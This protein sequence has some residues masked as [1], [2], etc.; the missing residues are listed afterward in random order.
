MR[1]SLE[2]ALQ[3]LRRN[4][5][6]Y[7]NDPRDPGGCTNHGITLAT[8]RAHG[9][10]SATCADVRLMTWEQAAAIYERV[11]WE[12]VMGD[13]LPAGIDLSVFDAAVNAGPS[14]AA[15]LLQGVLGVTQDGAIG[16]I[17]L[18]AAGAAS[19][20]ALID[21]YAAARL[22][23]YR[24]LSTWKTFGRGWS[25]RAEEVRKASHL[26]RLGAR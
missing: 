19:E 6:G 18:A 14:R 8:Y 2:A 24:G 3:V 1:S 15:K 20:A 7:V 16:P 22:T 25:R 12:A 10:P 11:Y 4:E 9:K 21:D 13:A 17:T 23:F 5:G 26:L